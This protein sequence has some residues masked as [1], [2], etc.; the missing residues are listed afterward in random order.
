MEHRLVPVIFG[1][2]CTA[3]MTAQKIDSVHVFQHLPPGQYSAG[4]AH[5]L[6]WKLYREHAPFRSIGK[7]HMTTVAELL[8]RYRPDKYKQ[9]ALPGLQ[10]VAMAFTKNGMQAIGVADD[11]GLIVNFTV[12]REYRISSLTEH[13]LVRAA[14]ARALIVE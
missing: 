6:V 8:E 3:S 12:G 5:A 10:Y 14:L 1:L 13:V 9:A 7:D 4:S 2:L 11:L